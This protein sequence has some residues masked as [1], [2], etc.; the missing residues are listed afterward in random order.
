MELLGCRRGLRFKY[1]SWLVW[2]CLSLAAFDFTPANAVTAP[3]ADE[4]YL[5]AVAELQKLRAAVLEARMLSRGTLAGAQYS[6][7]ERAVIAHILSTGEYSSPMMAV[8]SHQNA[9]EEEKGLTPLCCDRNG[10]GVLFRT[11][12]VGTVIP[13]INSLSLVSNRWIQYEKAANTA[14]S[15]H[16]GTG[17]GVATLP[18]DFDGAMQLANT[19]PSTVGFL[20]KAA[21]TVVSN[22]RLSAPLLADGSTEQSAI[23]FTATSSGVVAKSATTVGAQVGGMTWSVQMSQRPVVVVVAP[24][25]TSAPP[26]PT[27]ITSLGCGVS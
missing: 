22:D 18:L 16:S 3:S 15:Y 27:P 2:C 13:F 12:D 9:V 6:P 20:G 5:S 21:P 4:A 19:F 25:T 8:L 7:R 24:P 10:N 14:N 26:T 23:A 1:C 17:D 11:Q